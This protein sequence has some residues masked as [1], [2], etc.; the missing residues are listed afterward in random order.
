MIEGLKYVEESW[1]LVAGYRFPV[2]GGKPNT[3]INKKPAAGYRALI[4][5]SNSLVTGN[6]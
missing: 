4:N 5:N 6:R 2:S 3:A 1:G